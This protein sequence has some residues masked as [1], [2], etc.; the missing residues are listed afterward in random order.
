MHSTD[1]AN[2]VLPRLTDEHLWREAEALIDAH[3]RFLLTTHANPDGDGLGSQ[4]AL[5]HHLRARGKEV[6][7]VNPSPFPAHLGFLDPQ[8]EAIVIPDG[9][10]GTPLPPADA[11][12]ILD[13]SNWNRMLSLGRRLRDRGLP[14]LTIDHHPEKREPAGDIRLIDESAAA[15]GEL[16]YRLIERGEGAWSSPIV[17]A[18]Y[19]A[20]LTDTGSFRFSNTTPLTHRIAADLI[21]RGARPRGLYRRVYEQYTP[22]RLRLLGEV[23]ANLVVEEEGRLVHYLVTSEMQER[24]GAV[25][26]DL[27]GFIDYTYL[28]A[29]GEVGVQ[30]A[31]TRDGRTRVSLRS[32]GRYNVGQIAE[33]LGGGGHEHAAGVVLDGSPEATRRRVLAE[34]RALFAADEGGTGS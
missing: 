21:Q 34:C 18:L 8:G 6:R 29:T 20:I 31:Q 26:A 24:H 5:M 25:R 11:V 19:I 13:A 23:L 28:V 4:V 33:R 1:E 9:D 15:T 27:E 2:I 16:V 3:H 17:D 14:S 12:V 10:D 7:L 30:F 32:K 22:A